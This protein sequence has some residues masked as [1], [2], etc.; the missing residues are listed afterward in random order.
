MYSVWFIMVLIWIIQFDIRKYFLTQ[1]LSPLGLSGPE[2]C[3]VSMFTF[4]LQMPH[5]LIH[6]SYICIYSFLDKLIIFSFFSSDHLN[7][8]LFHLWS[9]TSYYMQARHQLATITNSSSVLLHVEFVTH[10][11]RYELSKFYGF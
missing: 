11:S 1:K 5:G 2:N 8:E 3:F 6:A 7:W 4:I 9:V 10:S